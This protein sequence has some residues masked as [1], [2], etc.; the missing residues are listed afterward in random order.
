MESWTKTAGA[1]DGALICKLTLSSR[2]EYILGA[3]IIGAFHGMIYEKA[4]VSF[5]EKPVEDKY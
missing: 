4:L 5:K 3:S 1:F 2:L